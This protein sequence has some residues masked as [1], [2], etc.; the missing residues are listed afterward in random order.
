MNKMSKAHWENVY[1][2]KTPQEVSWTQSVPETSLAMIK[3]AGDRA[4][5][6]IID[7]GGGDSRLVDFLLDD[8]FED[9]TVLDISEAAI[10]RAQ[11][12]LGERA[13]KV[14][15]IVTDILDFVPAR[16]YGIWHD[17]AT[18]HFLT[19]DEQVKHYAAT[20]AKAVVPEGKMIIATFAKDGP[21]KCSGLSITQYSPEE[22]AEVFSND[23][24]QTEHQFENHTTPFE[25][26]QHFLFAGFE[27]KK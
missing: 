2:T 18:F 3:A 21:L 9:I 1:E 26:Q 24:V 8:G 5:D 23:F 20:A 15:W 19:S 27:R 10:R 25:T 17:R 12:R 22:M 13:A 4:K 16:Q 11:N 7:I 14:T 6:G